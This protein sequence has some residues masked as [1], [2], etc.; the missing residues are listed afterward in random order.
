MLSSTKN[1]QFSE[2]LMTPESVMLMQRLRYRICRFG[3]ALDR[4]VRPDTEFKQTCETKGTQYH[5]MDTP[6]QPHM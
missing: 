5:D 3:H 1:G 6:L 4:L 2:M